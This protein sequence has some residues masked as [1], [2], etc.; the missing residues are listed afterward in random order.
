MTKENKNAKFNPANYDMSTT[1]GC[2]YKQ[3]K[4]EALITC[5]AYVIWGVVMMIS[6]RLTSYNNPLTYTFGFPTWVIWVIF[7]PMITW[8]AW[9]FVY[10]NYIFKE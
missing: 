4:K 3:S 1:F 10:V 5:A 9:T 8:L 6:A 7:V 2:S